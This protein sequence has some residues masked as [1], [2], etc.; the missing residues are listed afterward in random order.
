MSEKTGSEKTG[1]EKV[2]SEGVQPKAAAAKPGLSRRALTIIFAFAFVSIVLAGNI[3][4][5]YL[6]AGAT[7]E[8]AV[9]DQ[10]RATAGLVFDT[11]ISGRFDLL[12]R[13]HLV[14]YETKVTDPSGVIDI[15]A[16]EFDGD[17]RLL[18]LIVGRIELTSL[19]L[20]KPRL[21]IDLDGRAVQAES[22]IGRAMRSSEPHADRPLGV[23]TLVDGT[24]RIKSKAL[25]RPAELTDVNVTLDWRD[26]DSPAT[27]AGSLSMR[28]TAAEVTA[29]FARPSGLMRGDHSAVAFRLHSA[30]LDLSATGDLVSAAT[31]GFRGQLSAKSPTATALLELAGKQATLLAPFANLSLNADATVGIDPD[32]EASIDLQNLRLRADGNAYEGTLAFQSGERLSLSGTLATDQLALAPFFS[33]M[34]GLHETNGDWS[35]ARLLGTVPSLLD[36]DLRISAKHVRLAPLTVDDAALA[37]MTRGDRT[38]VA[39]VD[40][41]AYGGTTKGRISIGVANDA[42]TLRGSG[43]INGADASTLTWDAFGRQLAEGTV[44]GSANVET[45]GGS[46]ATLMRNLQGWAKGSATDGEIVG[47]DLSRALRESRRNDLGAALMALRG[48]RTAFRTLTFGAH[49]ADGIAT[50]DEGTAET[51]NAVLAIGGSADIGGRRFDLHLNATPSD[52]ATPGKPKAPPLAFG[53]QGPFDKVTLRPDI[54]R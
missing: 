52:V 5:P 50:L 13:P 54:A 11:K 3:A 24:T 42:V 47:A 51:T 23:V 44:S 35:S 10:L 53:V 14:F 30:P 25:R 28:G 1:S 6:F 20:I 15:D 2:Q 37:V 49:V 18:P 40:G 38:E 8:G 16:E 22:F 26:L 36:L 27:L 19:T 34:P 31:T 4:G 12:P 45:T 21:T 9:A 46:L 17:V 41:K 39:L 32:N 48:G 7:L 33:R 29:W 43:S